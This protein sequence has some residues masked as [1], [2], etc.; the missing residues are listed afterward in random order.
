MKKRLINEVN[1]PFL[2]LKNINYFSAR[3]Q[4][5]GRAIKP[6]AS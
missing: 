3:P 4:Y 1:Q 5:Y 6:T 2:Y